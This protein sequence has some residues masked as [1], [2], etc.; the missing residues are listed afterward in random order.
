MRLASLSVDLDGLDCY[1]RIH[2]L[3][4]APVAVPDPIFTVGLTRFL[5]LFDEAGLPATLFVIGRTAADCACDL[6]RA[7]RAGHELA[8]HTLAHPYEL[9]RLSPERIQ[10]EIEGGERRIEEAAGV[11]PVGFR[12]PGYAVSAPIYRLLAERGYRYD[13]SVFP[14]APYWLAKAATMAALAAVGRPS[15]ATL[16]RPRSLLA[17]RTP[18]RASLDEPYR[19][20]DAPFVTLPM[21]VAPFARVPFLGTLATCLPTRAAN[22]VYRSMRRLPHFSFELHGIDLLDASDVKDPRLA[23][24]QVDLRVPVSAKRR[25]LREVVRRLAWDFEVVTLER[26]AAAL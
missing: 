14:A 6:R 19:R 24:A 25:R 16:D 1:R 2:G 15:K 5:E 13:A 23:K 12:A 20:G 26:A 4:E 17:P 8:N 9:T 18:Y 11:R 7:V 10:E 3:P 22:L 21:A